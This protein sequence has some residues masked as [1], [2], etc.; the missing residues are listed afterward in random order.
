MR[1]VKATLDPPAVLLPDTLEDRGIPTWLVR[2]KK[3][4]R[5]DKI[6][7]PKLRLVTEEIRE[8]IARWA[9]DHLDQLKVAEPAIPDALDDRA[10]PDSI[11]MQASVAGDNGN[12]IGPHTARHADTAS[13]L[14]SYVGSFWVQSD[15]GSRLTVDY[16]NGA[17]L[18]MEFHLD[19]DVGPHT[20]LSLYVPAGGIAQLPDGSALSPGDSVEITVTIDPVLMYAVMQPSGLVFADANPAEL[21]VSYKRADRDFDRDGD[22]DADDDVVEQDYLGIWVKNHGAG[23]PWFPVTADHSLNKKWFLGYLEHFSDHAI[24][25]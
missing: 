7:W 12:G 9:D 22:V 2:K 20:F 14:E 1:R 5:I 11:A 17:S 25:W 21:Y 15:A 16:V 24:S 4:E 19:K 8:R 23:E 13:V 6:Y 10:S 18:E 3:G